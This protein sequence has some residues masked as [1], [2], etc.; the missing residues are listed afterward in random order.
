[1]PSRLTVKSLVKFIPDIFTSSSTFKFSQIADVVADAVSCAS[2]ACSFITVVHNFKGSTK[3]LNN[4]Q[5]FVNPS[6]LNLVVENLI[7]FC[8]KYF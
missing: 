8:K 1:M 2:S 4:R 5:A 7:A 3:F 6:G